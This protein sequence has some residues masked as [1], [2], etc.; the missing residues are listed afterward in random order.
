MKILLESLGY[1]R[2]SSYSYSLIWLKEYIPMEAPLISLL[3]LRTYLTASSS[4]TISEKR[5]FLAA[6]S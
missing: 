2:F 3:M 1:L 6:V 5:L 4:S